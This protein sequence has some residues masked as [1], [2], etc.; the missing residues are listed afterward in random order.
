MNV[1]GNVCLQ[2]QIFVVFEQ[3]EEFRLKWT[4]HTTTTGTTIPVNL[5]SVL[6]LHEV[7]IIGKWLV[8]Q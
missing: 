2:Y 5:T 3:M 8:V 7:H 6:T 1:G 4:Q